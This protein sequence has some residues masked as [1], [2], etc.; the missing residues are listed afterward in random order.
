MRKWKMMA[1]LLW[2]AGLMLP[3]LAHAAD[4]LFSEDFEDGNY[5]SRGWYDGTHFDLVDTEHASGL[6]SARFAFAKGATTWTGSAGAMRKRFAAADALYVSFYIKF[7]PGW[8]G[9]Q[10]AYH[11]H[12]IY[13][14]SDLDDSANAW[15]PL[16]NNFLDTYI[17][18]LSDIDSPFAIRPQLALQDQLNVNTAYGTPPNNLESLTENRSVTYCNTPVSSGAMGTCYADFSYYSANTWKDSFHA[19]SV[20]AWHHIEVFFKMNSISG[21]KGQKDGILQEWIDG[22]PVIAHDDVLYRTNQHPTMQWKQ[23]VF[24]PYIGDGAPVAETFYI[25]NLNVYDGRPSITPPAAP[26]GLTVE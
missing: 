2:A 22:T 7:A 17:E 19:L 23:F 9:S 8:R 3:I 21:G 13:I 11:P 14:L 4:L 26:D 5:L 20:N 6:H 10:R 24:A 18:F 1:L 12:M 25:D 15:S 16:A